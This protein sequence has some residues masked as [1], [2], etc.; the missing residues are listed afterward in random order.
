[1]NSDAMKAIAGHHGY[2]EIGFQIL[3][4]VLMR[5]YSKRIKQQGV[6]G[7]LIVLQHDSNKTAS[8]FGG[9]IQN[10]TS[11][12]SYRRRSPFLISLSPYAGSYFLA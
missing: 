7:R 2:C 10:L 8:E 4:L 11:F 1:M 5:Y 9:V 12:P 3:T 6:S